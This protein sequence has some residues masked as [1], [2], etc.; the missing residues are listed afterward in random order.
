MHINNLPVSKI[1]SETFLKVASDIDSFYQVDSLDD[2]NKL[3]SRGRRKRGGGGG[4]G[5]RPDGSYV[6]AKEDAETR[7]R[8]E[9]YVADEQAKADAGYT[10]PT[11]AS[12]LTKA[13]RDALQ[14]AGKIMMRLMPGM[15]VDA[16]FLERM[17]T[18]GTDRDR[19]FVRRVLTGTRNFGDNVDYR[20]LGP[21]ARRTADSLRE[22]ATA[23]FGQHGT[24]FGAKAQ[25]QRVA[26]EGKQD[27]YE[28]AVSR[29]DRAIDS[30]VK[31]RDKLTELEQI[32]QTRELT[33]QEMRNHRA[34][35]GQLREAEL[36]KTRA[37]QDVMLSAAGAPKRGYFGDLAR[38]AA[39][40]IKQGVTKI[41]PFVET[42]APTVRL[43][44]QRLRDAAAAAAAA[45]VPASGAS[46]GSGPSSSPGPGVPPAASAPAP[47][48]TGPGPAP[49][50]GPA[51]ASPTSASPAAA[52]SAAPPG[53]GAG[54]GGPSP[55]PT[56]PR[57]RP[58]SPGKPKPPTAGSPKPPPGAAEPKPRNELPERSPDPHEH[59]R[60]PDLY[61]SPEEEAAATAR[62]RELAAILVERL[63]PGSKK[64]SPKSE[65]SPKL[66]PVPS[67]S[68]ES[69]LEVPPM[70]DKPKPAA[71]EKPVEGMGKTLSEFIKSEAKPRTPPKKLKYRPE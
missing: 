71:S 48:P 3:A 29:R 31:I 35:V 33:P 26:V 47:G 40:R 61:A 22:D 5:G 44:R 38:R 2:L 18:T 37:D 69:K 64:S 20:S 30:S 11:Q 42:F 58:S 45:A 17:Y 28:S 56:G 68:G 49:S 32:A 53:P 52:A 24:S 19:D 70:I 25:A 59:G 46:S 4:G 27:E 6:K 16:T 51:A 65:P 57:P 34:M 23:H 8:Y 39:D 55:A 60:V 14:R 54:S 43:S 63:R 66:E 36:E 13:D 67:E 1:L 12:P 41:T 9:Q 50:A 21:I 10:S 62:A 7:K 15:G